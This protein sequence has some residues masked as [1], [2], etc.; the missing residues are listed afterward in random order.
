M[1]DCEIEVLASSPIPVKDLTRVHLHLAT[2]QVLAR[3]RVLGG[4]KAIAPGESGLAQLRL[5]A[6]LVAARGDRFILRR[7]SPLE[8][9]AGGV[10]LDAYP[11]KHSVASRD[12]AARVEALR[13]ADAAVIAARFVDESGASGVSEIDLGRRLAV[14]APELDEILNTLL[15]SGPAVVVSKSPR[16]LLA[17]GVVDEVGKRLDEALRAFQKKNPLLGGMPK[18]EL[19]EKAGAGAPAEVFDLI[20]GGLEEAK[21]L[22]VVK[23]LVSTFD[24]R[25]NLSEDETRARDLLVERYQ[26]AG[27]RPQALEEI[28]AETKLDTKLLERVQRVLLKDGTLVSISDGMVFHKDA[29]ARLKESVRSCKR[30]RERIDVAFF[31]EMA[32]VTRKHAIPLLEW[33]DRERVTQRSGNER[34]I[35]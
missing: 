21:R 30:E 8:T 12:D 27:V 5:E 2:A 33:L 24:H 34:V 1:L 22:R 7:Y 23:D 32:G 16:V 18:S 13:G 19:R 9:I 28:S 4:G 15:K 20:L 11:E 10:V 17:K 26:K 14:G 29:L 6:P 25:I 31:K 3:A 35:L